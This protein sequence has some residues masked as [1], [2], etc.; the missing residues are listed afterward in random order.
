[1]ATSE[2]PVLDSI[3]HVDFTHHDPQW[4]SLL[5]PPTTPPAAKSPSPSPSILLHTEPQS[6]DRYLHGAIIQP[7]ELVCAKPPVPIIEDGSIQSFV[8][9]FRVPRNYTQATTP[10]SPNNSFI[11]HAE[12]LRKTSPEPNLTAAPIFVYLC[13][14]PGSGQQPDRHELLN[15]YVVCNGYQLL[16][17]DYRGCGRSQ[18][19][20]VDSVLARR[21]R[22]PH[23]AVR[24]FQELRQGN[25]VRDL[26]AVRRFLIDFIPGQRAVDDKLVLLGQSY[27][28]WIALTYVD[29]YP[30]SI[31]SVLLTGG[32][33]PLGA[34]PEEVY[35]RLFDEVA[36]AN[37]LFHARYPDAIDM[38]RRIAGGIVAAEQSSS[39]SSSSSCSSSSRTTK[40]RRLGR[41]RSPGDED[42]SG[43]DVGNRPSLVTFASMGRLL[44]E[45]NGAD[46]LYGR[47][48][49]LDKRLAE[50][51]EPPRLEDMDT[52]RFNDRLSYAFDHEIQCYVLA[53]GHTSDWAAK[54]VRDCR[55]G[56]YGWISGRT[57]AELATAD[58]MH[59]LGEAFMPEH[60][61]D[62]VSLRALGGRD[63]ADEVVSAGQ[64][65][66]LFDMERLGAN[67]V[68]V[69]AVIYRRDMYVDADLAVEA[70]AM[71]GSVSSV[72]LP[73]TSELRHNAIRES[74]DQVIDI[75]RDLG[76]EGFPLDPVQGR[77]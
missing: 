56:A 43:R 61:D 22:E 9:S 18:A 5:T 17:L 55:S 16:L 8:L 38:I 21:S 19:L 30:G 66:T 58:K 64:T 44:G 40:R 52:H 46:K 53:E 74:A 59:F 72:R 35:T 23:G 69:Y 51:G 39:S 70:A 6:H 68:P 1:M 41:R 33:P 65:E 50:T 27:G 32:M 26:E 42:A 14:G 37:E 10:S 57:A 13:G 45:P 73:E 54:T 77:G 12:I 49:M 67:R 20:T 29:R 7:A 25:I 15:R 4:H 71:V 24:A 48:V 3:K 28:G 75:F 2:E 63:F 60:A 76:F 11:L 47:L 62:Y 31:R 34:S 36:R